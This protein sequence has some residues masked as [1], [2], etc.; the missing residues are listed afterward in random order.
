MNADDVMKVVQVSSARWEH[1]FRCRAGCSATG[2]A[3]ATSPLCLL[4]SCLCICPYDF[5][6]ATFCF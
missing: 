3:T 2:G 5:R 1:V 4:S 6:A